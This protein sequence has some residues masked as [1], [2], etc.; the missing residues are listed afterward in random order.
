MTQQTKTII[1]GC[2][3]VGTKIAQEHLTKQA[4]VQAIVRSKSSEQAL[5]DQGVSCTRC[6]FDG[7]PVSSIETKNTEVYVFMPPPSSGIEDTRMANMLG[8]FAK[9]GQPQRIVY[10]STTGV[11]GDCQGEWIDETRTVN[12]Q[13]DRAKRRWDAECQLRDWQD[14]TSMELVILR[15][16]GI[17]GAGK[18]PLA[19]LEKKLPMVRE[20]DAPFTNRIHVAD[21]VLICLAA[22]KKGV[23]GEIYHACDGQQDTMTNYFN[24]IADVF[25]YQR[26]ELITLAQAAEQLSAGMMSYM[27]ESRRLSNQKL[28]HLG[29]ELLY[30]TLAEGLNQCLQE[31]QK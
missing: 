3:Y 21:L 8:F 25:G 17:Y 9:N 2:G 5:N 6:D 4:P 16:A 1:V 11:Y 19:R 14:E 12:P 7:L 18:L 22:M 23:S 10:I 28:E 27:K 20:V 30:P 26:P 31:M 13:V 29:V 15:V 24:Q